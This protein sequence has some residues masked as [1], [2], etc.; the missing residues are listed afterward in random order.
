MYVDRAMERRNLAAEALA[1]AVIGMLNAGVELKEIET[2]FF[3]MLYALANT[4]HLPV[5][6]TH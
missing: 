2:M 4:D 5:G 3:S 6:R 1:R